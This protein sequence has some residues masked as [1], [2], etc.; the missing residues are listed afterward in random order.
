MAHGK[1]G[2]NLV[3]LI[4]SREMLQS[5]AF[6]KDFFGECG[7]GRNCGRSMVGVMGLS[8]EFIIVLTACTSNISLENSSFFPCHC[9]QV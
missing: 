3:K 4:T 9:K 5:W 2:A 6:N 7:E 1:T 8:A